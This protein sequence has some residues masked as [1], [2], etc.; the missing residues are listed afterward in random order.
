M[1]FLKDDSTAKAGFAFPDNQN[2]MISMVQWLCFPSFAFPKELYSLKLS[3]MYFTAIPYTCHVVGRKHL[4][5]LFRLLDHSD[6]NMFMMRRLSITKDPGIWAGCSKWLCLRWSPLWQGVSF[7]W[8]E[9]TRNLHDQRGG[10]LHFASCLPNT[11]SLLLYWLK[12][13]VTHGCPAKDSI[14]S[15]S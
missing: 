6:P 5:L 15:H 10:H 14:S 7:V 4:S 9:Q 13:K 11:H 1:G 3:C 12:F 8:E 2:L